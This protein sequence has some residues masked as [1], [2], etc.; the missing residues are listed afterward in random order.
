MRGVVCKCDKVFCSK[1]FPEKAHQCSFDWKIHHP[2]ASKHTMTITGKRKCP[3]SDY[4]G[5]NLAF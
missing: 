3:S 2:E 4:R 1:H 5:D